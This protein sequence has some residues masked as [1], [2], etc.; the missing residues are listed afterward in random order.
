MSRTGGMGRASRQMGWMR[1][2]C[3]LVPCTEFSIKKLVLI[4]IKYTNNSLHKSIVP[5]SIIQY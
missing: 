4:D 3:G 1:S 5:K 2:E